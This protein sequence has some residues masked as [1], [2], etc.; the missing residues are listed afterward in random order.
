[1][2]SGS[3]NPFTWTDALSTADAVSRA[4]F[5]E[6]VT[7]TLKAGTHTA[8]FGPRGTGKTSFLLELEEDLRKNHGED[9]PPWS[10]IMIDLRRAISLPAF[11]GA[12]SDA[13]R[14][15]PDKGLRRRAVNAF[16]DVEKEFGINLG[17]VRAGVRSASRRSQALN[18]E[19]ILHAQL[20]VLPKLTDRIVIAFDEFQRLSHCPGEPLSQIRS[21]LMGPAN[22]GRVSLML[23]G[24]LREKLELMLKTD[25][26]PIWDQA[27]GMELPELPFDEFVAYLQLRFEASGRAIED[28]AVEHLVGLGGNHPKRTQQ[29][30]WNV[31]ERS[32]GVIGI[33][34]DLVDASYELLLASEDQ[35]AQVVDNLLAGDEAEINQA[36]VL[37]MLGAGEALGSRIVSKKY[38]LRDESAA[39]R[40]ADRLRKR[41]IITGE[42]ANFHVVDPLLAEWLRRQDPVWVGS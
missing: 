36:R 1:M 21:A 32:L 4:P 9:A 14:E 23:T 29:L 12:I 3:L 35:V 42:R 6:R 22:T 16:R 15:H 28:A 34:K 8:L 33:D 20:A 19:V 10:M 27:L 39:L 17:V 18:E 11:I 2:T 38:G 5:T 24:S 30:A 13:L 31:W 25:T 37:F 7:R 26:E 41:G 40:A